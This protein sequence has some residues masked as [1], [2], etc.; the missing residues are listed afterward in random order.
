MGVYNMKLLRLWLIP[1]LLI[2]LISCNSST[3]K[4]KWMK[5]L[6]TIT[7]YIY[8]CGFEQSLAL[9]KQ[10]EKYRRKIWGTIEYSYPD[11]LNDNLEDFLFASKKTYDIYMCFQQ[12]YQIMLKEIC[13]YH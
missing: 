6:Q 13:F 12:K 1:I 5:L 8:Y 4:Q 3:E 7:F 9:F 11:R 2:F 10:E